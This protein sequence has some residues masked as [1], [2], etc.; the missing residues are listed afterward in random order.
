[1]NNIKR[2]SK[3][4][5][6]VLFL[7]QNLFAIRYSSFSLE[8]I[9]EIESGVEGGKVK[10]EPRHKNEDTF[11]I[12][13]DEE[14][15]LHSFAVFDGHGR[16]PIT[17]DFCGGG[18]SS[19]LKDN[20]LGALSKEFK[21]QLE[22]PGR[23]A[24]AYEKTIR[25]LNQELIKNKKLNFFVGSTAT[26]ATIFDDRICFCNVGDSRSVLVSKDGKI[27]YSTKDQKVDVENDTSLLLCKNGLDL[28]RKIFV[29]SPSKSELCGSYQQFFEFDRKQS[30]LTIYFFNLCTQE[31]IED[32]DEFDRLNGFLGS[33]VKLKAECGEDASI[34]SCF[35]LGRNFMAESSDSSHSYSTTMYS[36]FG[37]LIFESKGFKPLPEVFTYNLTGAEKY[38]I[39]AS[40]GF[41]DVVKNEE[42]F[43][44]IECISSQDSFEF[45]DLSQGLCREAENRSI[46][47]AGISDDITVIVVDLELDSTEN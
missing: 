40:D 19:F 24:R 41:W 38:L 46:C 9:L 42:V 21:M 11:D 8:N 45:E 22:V 28:Y 10:F 25:V 35:Y 18:V 32:K 33:D 34:D 26:S 47:I 6:I 36:S 37:D 27:L 7:F 30:K 5:L 44:L 20:F 13:L 12:K 2:L 23:L 14:Q 3:F 16:N 17:G 39:L 4:S 29:N 1:M 31:W 15:G 43:A